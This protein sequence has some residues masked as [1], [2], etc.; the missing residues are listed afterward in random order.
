MEYEATPESMDRDSNFQDPGTTLFV[1]ETGEFIKLPNEAQAKK[2]VAVFMKKFHPEQWWAQKVSKFRVGMK[3]YLC[4]YIKRDHS[5]AHDRSD[6]ATATLHEM[7]LGRMTIGIP[8]NVTDTVEHSE[9]IGQR[10]PATMKVQLADM[11]VRDVPILAK[12]GFY[13]YHEA[14]PANIKMY[15]KM[16]GLTIGGN[17]TE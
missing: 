2:K 1:T 7:W 17:Q 10:I 9:T 11:S 4:G 6:I 12:K 5:K 15:Q 14:T 3:D 16:C 13:S 8:K